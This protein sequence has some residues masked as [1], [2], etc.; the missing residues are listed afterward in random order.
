MFKV[1]VTSHLQV[2]VYHQLHSFW[3]GV[4]ALLL[5]VTDG[6]AAAFLLLGTAFHWKYGSIYSIFHVSETFSHVKYK[7]EFSL[8]E[9]CS[10]FQDK[11]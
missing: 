11:K 3:R 2:L 5:F 8:K 4:R 9:E 1:M 6:E 10:D 7:C